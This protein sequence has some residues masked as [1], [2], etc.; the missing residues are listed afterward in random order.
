[1]LSIK[2][3]ML[4]SWA[5]F[6]STDVSLLTGCVPASPAYGAFTVPSGAT[7]GAFTV[8]AAP[9]Y[10]SFTVPSTTAYPTGC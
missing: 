7:Y 2:F 5:T 9:T 6:T 4:T 1:M 8:V 10:G 3:N